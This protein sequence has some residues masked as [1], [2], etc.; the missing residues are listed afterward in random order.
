MDIHKRRRKKPSIALLLVSGF[1]SLWN[2]MISQLI[3]AKEWSASYSSTGYSDS[4]CRTRN[5]HIKMDLRTPQGKERRDR[6]RSTGV[7]IAAAAAAAASLQSCPPLC[8]PIGSSPP[9]APVPGVLQARTLEWAAI[10]FSNAWNCS[11]SILEL[12]LYL[13]RVVF[14]SFPHFSLFH[15]HYL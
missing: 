9:G 6:L 13:Q 3:R 14:F 12:F 15:Y 10:S 8:N 11:S 4:L 7:C 2:S 5:T 1:F